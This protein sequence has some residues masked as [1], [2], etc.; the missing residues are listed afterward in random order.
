MEENPSMKGNV[1]LITGAASGS[2]VKT[3]EASRDPEQAK[4]LFDLTMR[5]GGVA[6]SN[7][8]GRLIRDERDV[9]DPRDRSGVL[10]Y[11]RRLRLGR[12]LDALHVRQR[13]IEEPERQPGAGV[14]RCRFRAS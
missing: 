14:N 12:A 11:L 5:Q 4:S 1:A 8:G 3:A 2:V 10:G 7:H 9:R 6:Q 13:G